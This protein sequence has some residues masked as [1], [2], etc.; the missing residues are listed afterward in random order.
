MGM[1]DEIREAS[2][3]LI[4]MTPDP[5]KEHVCDEKFREAVEGLTYQNYLPIRCV[6]LRRHWKVQVITKSGLFTELLK[7]TIKERYS[8]VL[9]FDEIAQN[10]IITPYAITTIECRPSALF[11][12]VMLCIRCHNKAI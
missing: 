10:R 8:D 2:L 3:V 9:Y 12:M 5:K 4:S 11:F 7:Q 1:P 6:W